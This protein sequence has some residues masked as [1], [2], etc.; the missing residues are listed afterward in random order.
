MLIYVKLSGK[1]LAVSVLCASAVARTSRCGSRRWSESPEMCC[2]MLGGFVFSPQS[3]HTIQSVVQKLQFVDF[4][5]AKFT[6]LHRT[7]GCQCF[8]QCLALNALAL[9]V[10]SSEAKLSFLDD[11]SK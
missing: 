2:K 3:V 7:A 1:Q 11:Y 9:N 10:D 5:L 4:F 8:V 6:Q